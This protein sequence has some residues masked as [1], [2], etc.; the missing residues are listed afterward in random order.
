MKRQFPPHSAPR[1]R[2]ARGFEVH[3]NVLARI[4]TGEVVTDVLGGL[5]ATEIRCLMAWHLLR[6]QPPAARE[7]RRPAG[8]GAFLRL[9]PAGAESSRLRLTSVQ[10]PVISNYRSPTAGGRRKRSK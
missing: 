9:A 8:G 4:C 7:R 2:R 5:S 1:G 3:Q 6:R 10:L